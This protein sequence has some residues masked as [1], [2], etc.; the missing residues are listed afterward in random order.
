MSKIPGVSRTSLWE[1]WKE[2]RRDVRRLSNRDVVDYLEYDIDPNVWIQQLLRDID[3]GSYEPSRP[4]RFTQAKSNGFSRR[5][6]QPS[7]PDA[8]LYRA[9][10]TY[11][12]K[13]ARKN[14]VA[15]AYFEQ[16]TLHHVTNE[17][18]ANATEDMRREHAAYGYSSKRRWQ[19]WLRYDE[20]RRHLI[21]R[22]VYPYIVVADV[23]NF[24]DSILYGRIADALTGTVDPRVTGL[25]FFVLERLSVR[26]AYTES[27]RTGLPVDEFDCSRRLAHLVLFPHDARMV[28]AFGSTAYVRWMDDQSIGVDSKA[29]GIKALAHLGESLARLHLT[30]NSS[31]SRVLSLAQARNHFHFNTNA[32][33]RRLDSRPHPKS[34]NELRQYRAAYRL[35][36]KRALKNEGVGEWEKILKWFYRIAAVAKSRT[37]RRRAISDLL[38]C[39]RLTPR[40]ADYVRVTGTDVEYI[41]FVRAVCEHPEQVYSDVPVLLL[42]GMLRLEASKAAASSI[43]QLAIAVLHGQGIPSPTAACRSTAALLLLR[44]GDRRSIPALKRVV[45]REDGN[46]PAPLVRAAAVVLA[47]YGIDEYRFVRRRAAQLLDVNLAYLVRLVE[48]I[49]RYE[50]V[51]GRY[52]ARLNLHRDAVA[53][54]EFVDMRAVMAARLLRLNRNTKVKQ[55][56]DNRLAQM[57]AASVSAYDVALLDRL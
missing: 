40:I 35:A 49:Q 57:R 56:L 6:T 2:V 29:A 30:P 21:F 11:C 1:A 36:W 28:D 16:A 47:S 37:L 51:P 10:T 43:R 20:Y 13:R 4:T 44:F 24:F 15:H 19:A 8:V 22:R 46:V 42:E 33:L 3:A 38:A 41:A 25:L 55:W 54:I 17:A 48:R 14:E 45:Q 39:P 27:P 52:K 7:I 5:M 31:K 50:D 12:Y 26:D 34:A 9:L 23:T 53:G 32:A 18:H